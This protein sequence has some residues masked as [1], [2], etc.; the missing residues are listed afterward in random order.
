M[1]SKASALYRVAQAC[2]SRHVRRE[3]PTIEALDTALAASREERLLARVTDAAR[4]MATVLR[5]RALG[6][7]S[8]GIPTPPVAV[9]V[10]MD[11]SKCGLVVDPR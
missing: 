6:H 1:H 4:G 2:R 3:W 7:G 8:S 9:E 10:Q 11:V 5:C